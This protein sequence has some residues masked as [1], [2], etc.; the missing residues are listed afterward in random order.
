M[1]FHH[2]MAKLAAFAPVVG[3][4]RRAPRRTL[5]SLRRPVAVKQGQSL[6]ELALLLPILLLSL[7]GAGNLGFALQQ[8]TSL[9]QVTQ[10]AAQY[11]LA[12]PAP[13]TCGLTT[14]NYQT[15][16]EN[17][18]ATYITSTGFLA[19]PRTVEPT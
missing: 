7:L 9:T 11:L 5:H 4:C 15:C 2:T 10:Q 3:A 8:Q 12:N 1:R 16:T 14:N 13:T 18:V 19:A 6:T 17:Q